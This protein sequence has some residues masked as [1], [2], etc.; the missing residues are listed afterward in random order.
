[1]PVN[2]DRSRKLSKPRQ[3]LPREGKDIYFQFTAP[4]ETDVNS[5]KHPW[6]TPT[7]TLPRE[8]SSKSK[9]MS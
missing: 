2:K 7:P 3:P 8:Q 6:R 1:M 9:A 4:K 5:T